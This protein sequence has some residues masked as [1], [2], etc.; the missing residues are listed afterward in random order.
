MRTAH[1]E[2]ELGFTG[3]VV[4]DVH[5]QIVVT[6]EVELDRVRCGVDSRRRSGNTEV[7]VDTDAEAV[8]Q[9][10]VGVG[11]CTLVIAR[12]VV[13][14]EDT[15]AG[16]TSV[17]KAADTV[18]Y[19]VGSTRAVVD[20]GRIGL[21]AGGIPSE[22][23][24]ILRVVRIELVLLVAALIL[25]SERERALDYLRFTCQSTFIKVRRFD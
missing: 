4:G 10:L 22:V 20:A 12:S 1:I 16:G 25:N 18:F 3:T 13:E 11:L 2:N 7:N 17:H 15:V 8:V 23:D 14:G 24:V 21:T 19:A 9:V 6:R 5:P